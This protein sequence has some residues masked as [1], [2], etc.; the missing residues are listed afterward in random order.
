MKITKMLAGGVILL[1][2]FSCSTSDNDAPMMPK[3]AETPE[4]ISSQN[5][6]DNTFSDL[7][8]LIAKIKSMTKSEK[9]TLIGTYKNEDIQKINDALVELEDVHEDVR[10]SLDLSKAS[11]ITLLKKD[12]DINFYFN[13]GALSEIILPKGLS[14]IGQG[15]FERCIGL[16]SVTI[17]DGVTS[18]DQGVF[19]CCR[20]LVNINIPDSVTSIG[21][22]AFFHCVSLKSITIPAGVVSMI[23]AF[24]GCSELKV[25]N[26]KGTEEQW[27]A[28]NKG[29]DYNAW[30]RGCPPDMVINYNYKE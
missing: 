24:D 27:N 19:E 23:D 12:K 25:I 26:Y 6:S 30:N 16:T 20:N 14:N 15:A 9:L 28:I 5:K 21:Y 10:V 11:G 13:T 4:I 22:G 3:I 1:T 29:T 7:S 17:P 8:A 2:L 18:I